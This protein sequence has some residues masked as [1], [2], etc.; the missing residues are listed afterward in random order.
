VADETGKLIAKGDIQ[1]SYGQQGSCLF[2]LR[3]N[4]VPGGKKFYRVQV[5]QRGETSYTEAEAKAGI[6]LAIRSPAPNPTGTPP[7]A[8]P[9]PTPNPAPTTQPPRTAVPPTE[10]PEDPESAS[11]AQLQRIAHND[12][13]FV[14]AWLADRWVP[15]ISSKRLGIVAE[16]TVWN[17][18]KILSEHLQLR[19]QFPEARL[20]WSGDWSTFDAPDF[21][22]TI[23]GDTFPDAAGA[24]AWCKRKNLDRDHCYAKIVSTTHPVKGSTVF[25]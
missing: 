20:L 9:S 15:Q 12:R 22:V 23:A 13:G 21:W 6:N 24:L 3:V 11:L 5:A 18:A 1:S 25:N 7:P 4:D 10:T 14:T 2:L 19:A 17:D 16:G 8:G